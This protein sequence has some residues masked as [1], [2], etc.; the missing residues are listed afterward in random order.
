MH[1]IDLEVFWEHFNQETIFD[2]EISGDQIGEIK[3]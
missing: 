3:N 2:S 1:Q